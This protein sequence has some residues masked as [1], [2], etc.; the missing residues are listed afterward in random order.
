M[1]LGPY[2][3]P[4]ACATTLTAAACKRVV[5]SPLCLRYDD[6]SSSMQEGSDDGNNGL[7]GSAKDSALTLV[8]VPHSCGNNGSI[9][10]DNG[11]LPLL[12]VLCSHKQ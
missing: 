10:M 12:I 8:V 1:G 6:N 9:S 11:A 7:G 4:S 3:H 5:R 2:D